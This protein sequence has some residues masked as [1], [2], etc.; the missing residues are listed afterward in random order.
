MA[1]WPLHCHSAEEEVFVI[2]TGTGTCVLGDREYAVRPGHVIARPAG[3]RVA[4]TL[5]GGP[6]GMTYLACGERDTADVIWYPHSRKLFFR[7]LGVITRVE[8]VSY[9]DGEE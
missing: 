1:S 4:H 8:T 5:R 6:E 2:L 3:S 7:G 9:W